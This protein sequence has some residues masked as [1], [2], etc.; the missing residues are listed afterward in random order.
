MQAANLVLRQLAQRPGL[1]KAL[2]IACCTLPAAQLF[3]EW[4]LDALG[5]NPL[6]R[7]Q[8][9]TGFTCL[10]LLIVGLALTPARQL[11]PW[12]ARAG[13]WEWGKRQADW[14]WL[15]RIRRILGVSAF[16][17]GALH[18]V[19]YLGLD[20]T[21]DWRG[22]LLDARD[23]RFVVVGWMALLIMLPLALTSTDGMV[24]RL[25]RH[26]KTLHQLNYVVAV[27]AATHFVL[28]AK[29]GVRRPWAYAAIIAGLL[30]YRVWMRVSPAPLPRV[31]ADLEARRTGPADRTVG[32]RLSVE[33]GLAATEPPPAPRSP[34]P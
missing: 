4:R 7:L 23:R 5:I 25:G 1:L 32:P 9:F 20:Q 31:D 8:R 26:W 10:M 28:L 2:T 33:D 6:E 27:L 16:S 21:W 3:V 34:S 29:A 11:L 17:Y 24:R 13:R 19:V 18:C 12:F 30:A 15:L 14:N 22:A